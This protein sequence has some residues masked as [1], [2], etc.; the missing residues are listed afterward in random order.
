MSVLATTTLTTSVGYPVVSSQYT[1]L[2]LVFKKHVATIY[3]VDRAFAT[4]CQFC[5]EA[6]V[7]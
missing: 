7:I 5:A 6:C 3:V 1:Y 2:H 4:N